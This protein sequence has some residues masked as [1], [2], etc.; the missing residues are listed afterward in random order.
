MV[1]GYFSRKRQIWAFITGIIFYAVDG[2]LFFIVEDL[3]SIGFHA[4]AI[5][6]IIVGIN[7]HFKLKKL[8]QDAGNPDQNSMKSG[9]L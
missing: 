6:F 7:A 1:F 9:T 5:F 3:L 8:E 2:L 4:L